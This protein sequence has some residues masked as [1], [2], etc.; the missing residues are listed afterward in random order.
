MFPEVGKWYMFNYALMER[1]GKCVGSSG[2]SAAFLTINSR[3]YLS[4]FPLIIDTPRVYIPVKM[5][6]K[7]GI[8]GTIYKIDSGE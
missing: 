5:L 7:V 1:V 3:G 2:D 8:T 6:K 4:G